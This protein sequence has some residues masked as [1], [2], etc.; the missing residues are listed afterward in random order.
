MLFTRRGYLNPTY[1][2]RDGEALLGSIKTRRGW[3]FQAVAHM[4]DRTVQF[5]QPSWWKRDFD[6]VDQRSGLVVATYDMSTW[7]FSD[8]IAIADVRYLLRRSAWKSRA[9]LT[10]ESGGEIL[11]ITSRDWLG[12]ALEVTLA[13]D[14]RFDDEIELLV[15]FSCFAMTLAESD[16]SA[17]AA[18]A[19]TAAT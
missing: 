6:A 5:R 2:L 9:K 3:K 4:R 7:R 17:A 16:S 13:P 10:D 1:E 15:Y 12:R 19:A 8:T 14:V 11:S 18:V